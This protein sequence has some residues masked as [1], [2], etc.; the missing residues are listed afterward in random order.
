MSAVRMTVLNLV[1]S[2]TPG[3]D[4]WG[5]LGG[6]LTGAAMAWLLGPAFVVERY[7]DGRPRIE[8]RSPLEE[9]W[10]TI[11]L[12]VAILSALTA[13]IIF[14]RSRFAAGIVPVYNPLTLIS[15]KDVL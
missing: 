5:H 1:I 9:R 2:L 8:D 7:G 15:W 11:L 14:A 4:L 3:I 12:G 13:L 10:W 6:L